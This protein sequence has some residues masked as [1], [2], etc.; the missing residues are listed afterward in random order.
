MKCPKVKQTASKSSDKKNKKLSKEEKRKLP[1]KEI[2]KDLEDLVKEYFLPQEMWKKKDVIPKGYLIIYL[3]EF[4]LD[5]KSFEQFVTNCLCGEINEKEA[6]GNG[7]YKYHGTHQWILRMHP[8]A[9][10][11]KAKKLLH[12][13]KEEPRL[14]Q[15][16]SFEELYD[17]VEKE[18][19]KWFGCLCNYDFCLRFGWHQKPRIEPKDYVYLHSNPWESA[20]I[21]V[22]LN[23]L[24]PFK[25]RRI[26]YDAF[27]DFFT[28]ND[29]TAKDI[30]NFL[31][32]FK[33]EI[34]EIETKYTEAFTKE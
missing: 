29:M 8:N 30:E 21:L 27:P 22:N 17:A 5:E 19:V 20:K 34:K 32:I 9:V 6:P 3:D 12:L 25:E 2:E 28:K 7:P 16:T 23:V 26:P 1:M 15:A 18:K 10:D 31:C 13:F 14:L 24:K 11:E 4:N 33:N